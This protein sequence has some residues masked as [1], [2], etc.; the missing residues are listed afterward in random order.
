MGALILVF[1]AIGG[2]WSAVERATSAL[3]RLNRISTTSIAGRRAER[4][5]EEASQRF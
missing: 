1:G 4:F 3:K 2:D 5:N